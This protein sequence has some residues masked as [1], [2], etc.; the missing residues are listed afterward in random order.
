MYPCRTNE[1]TTEY[2]LLRCHCF[3]TQRSELSD[4][5]WRLDPSFSILNTKEK[6]VHLLCGSTSNSSSL[7][8]D[9]FKLVIKFLKS[10]GR[11]N[12]SLIFDQ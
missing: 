8:K 5:L 2:F 4:N 3:A 1:E 9:V 11:F 6:V 10:T 12:K 7:N